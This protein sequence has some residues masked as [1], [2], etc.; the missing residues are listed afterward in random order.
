MTMLAGA[1]HEDGSIAI[2][3]NPVKN[4]CTISAGNGASITSISISNAVG[5]QMIIVPAGLGTSYTQLDVS[6]LTSGMYIINGYTTEGSFT[7]KIMVSR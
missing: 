3:P 4:S 5:Q 1:I 2:F 6:S 7:K